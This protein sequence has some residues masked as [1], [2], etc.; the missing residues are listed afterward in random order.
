M[1]EIK[2][3][4]ASTLSALNVGGDAEHIRVTSDDE[5]LQAL[6][7]AK[8]TNSRVHIRGEG[9]NTFFSNSLTNLLI[10]T[11]GYSSIDI[12]ER[13]TDVTLTVG[14]GMSWD[15]LVKQTVDKNWWGIENLSLI[16]GTVGASPV[17]NIGAYGVEL[18][19][20]CDSVRVY[21]KDKDR[22]STFCKSACGFGYRDSLFK[23]SAGRYII[24][25]V[26][27]TLSKTSKPILTYRPLDTLQGKSDISVVEIREKVIDIRS[28]KLPD[29]KEYPNCGSFFKNP[30]IDETTF[31]HLEA[32]Y[33]N[34]VYFKDKDMYKIPAAWLI[35]YVA[36][37]KGQM[38]N[39]VGTWKDQALVVVNYGT[40]DA[41]D[42]VNFA[43]HI[44]NKI[45][46]ETGIILEQ[47]VQFVE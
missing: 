10:I 2:T 15:A 36:K 46:E 29:Y 35:E 1:E 31:I 18:S 37:M 44:T 23:K 34:V 45:K 20:V 40:K 12:D 5:L 41:Q 42:I 16:P 3:V 26:T 4:K 11:I 47:E 38:F 19:L 22:F 9:T 27:L 21:D 25:H 8:K 24:T 32:K 43:T 39:H 30:T 14:A 6:A 7:Y 28:A 13:L 17:Q 33:P